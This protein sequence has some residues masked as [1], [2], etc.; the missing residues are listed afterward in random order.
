MKNECVH[1][2]AGG[3]CYSFDVKDNR[4]R[5]RGKKRQNC[6]Y[7]QPRERPSV[8]RVPAFATSP[9]EVRASRVLD[10]IAS[11]NLDVDEIGN[12]IRDLLHEL[13]LDLN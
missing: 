8:P 5:L 11:G 7:F 4:C 2:D 3:C 1:R 6:P 9:L 12:L 13:R 10:H